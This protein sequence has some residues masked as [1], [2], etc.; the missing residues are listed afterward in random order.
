VKKWSGPIATTRR[1]PAG[2]L[3]LILLTAFQACSTAPEAPPVGGDFALTLV[4]RNGEVLQAR[5]AG[6]ILELR[7]GGGRAGVLAELLGRKLPGGKGAGR[8]AGAGGDLWFSL[9]PEVVDDELYLRGR[10]DEG[11]WTGTLVHVSI[12]GPRTAGWFAAARIR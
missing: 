8:F 7:E 3:L 12:A 4:D 10:L 2:V 6:G 1:G 11:G 9:L 5:L